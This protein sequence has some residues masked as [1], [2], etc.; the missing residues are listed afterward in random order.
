MLNVLG[1]APKSYF[2]KVAGLLA[3]YNRENAGPCGVCS[4]L[5]NGLAYESYPGHWAYDLI[6]EMAERYPELM[7]FFLD[8][9]TV[10]VDLCGGWTPK[11]Q[12]FAAAL[13]GV[14]QRDLL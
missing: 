5:H 2:T 9:L 10:S 3:E 4:Y 7:W 13:L 11:R 14:I 1:T 8:N 12:A 6:P